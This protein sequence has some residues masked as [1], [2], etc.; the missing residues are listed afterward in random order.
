MQHINTYFRKSHIILKMVH[1]LSVSLK[2]FYYRLARLIFYRRGGSVKPFC[3]P[4]LARLF[5]FV[6]AWPVKTFLLIMSVHLKVCHHFASS[7]RQGY[8]PRV[9]PGLMQQ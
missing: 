3:R 9:K 2:V 1:I 4:T 8:G 6:M 7:T 5:I